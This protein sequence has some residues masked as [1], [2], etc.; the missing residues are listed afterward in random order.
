MGIGDSYWIR[1][2]DS[3]YLCVYIGHIRK[4]IEEDSTRPYFILTER[5]IGYR[6]IKRDH[7]VKILG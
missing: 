7:W 6:F 2:G 3:Y 1:Q 5:G 4:K